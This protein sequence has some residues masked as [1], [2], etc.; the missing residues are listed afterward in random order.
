MLDQRKKIYKS[1]EERIFSE[2]YNF[3]DLL[4][5]QRDSKLRNKID[6]KENLKNVQVLLCWLH[7][8]LKIHKHKR[9]ATIKRKFSLKNPFKRQET[10]KV[11]HLFLGILRDND[12]FSKIN[13]S[14]IGSHAQIT[15]NSSTRFLSSLSWK[16]SHCTKLEET[17]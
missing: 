3:E 11:L 5:D 4:T 10:T 16:T 8:R 6:K 13:E 1:H 7:R 17:S 2:N 15:A 14:A 9:S 12:G